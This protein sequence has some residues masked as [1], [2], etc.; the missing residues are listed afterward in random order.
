M[1]DVGRADVKLLLK[2]LNVKSLGTRN[3]MEMHTLC[4]DTKQDPARKINNRVETYTRGWKLCA[5]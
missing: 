1:A 2:M 5:Q 4:A 3:G